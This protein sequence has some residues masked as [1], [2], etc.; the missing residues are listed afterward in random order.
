MGGKEQEYP[1]K[2]YFEEELRLWRELVVDVG[3]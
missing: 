2:V 1:F 3:K